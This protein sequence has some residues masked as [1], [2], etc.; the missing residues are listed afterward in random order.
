MLLFGMVCLSLPI[1]FLTYQMRTPSD[2]TRLSKG[3]QSM[4][5]QGVHLHVFPPSLLVEGDLLVKIDGV[6]LQ[7]LADALFDLNVPRPEWQIGQQVNYTVE[8]FGQLIN[9]PITLGPQPWQDIL[10]ENWGVL[11]FTIVLQMLALFVIWQRP[12]EPAART[13][14]I[15]GFTASH[16][17]IWSSYLQPYELVN[18][19][20][21]W[22][23]LVTNMSLWLTNWPAAVHLAF[24][25]PTPLPVIKRRPWLLGGIYL[26]SFAIYFA[27]IWISRSSAVNTLDWIGSW[28]RGDALAAIILFIPLLIGIILQYRRNP[29]GPERAKIQWVIFSCIFSGGMAVG[30]YLIPELFDL[31]GLGVN[32]VGVLL[33]PFPVAIAIA[34]WRHRLF[35]IEVIIRRTLVYGTLTLSLAL[36]YFSGVILLQ[37]LLG[38]I[39]GQTESPVAVVLSTLT[40]AALFNPLRRWVQISIDRRFFRQKY[41]QE[42][43]LA[44]FS[45]RLRN[46]VEIEAVHAHLLSVVQNT[47][48]PE[49]TILWMLPSKNRKTEL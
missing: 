39:T 9:I 38:Q 8:R 43:I 12:Q 13:L 37:S 44:D 33:L 3:P 2:G 18:G 26:S 35:D 32:V 17:Y 30:L 6:S 11:L 36:I 10:K 31:P 34:I 24:T 19:S 21:F 4:N 28:G 29:I 16:F 1:A 45:I 25:F 15:W 27:T 14:F 42:L 40:I 23:Y 48:Q 41:D 46:E 7:D 20:G 22:L 5:A 49:Q 47:L